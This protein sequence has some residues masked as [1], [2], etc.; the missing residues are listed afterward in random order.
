MLQRLT[1]AQALNLFE[2]AETGNCMSKGF[3]IPSY[4]PEGYLAPPPDYVLFSPEGYINEPPI[5]LLP[6]SHTHRDTTSP[7]RR[8]STTVVLSCQV[9]WSHPVAL[10]LIG[11][12]TW[13]PEFAKLQP[14]CIRVCAKRWTLSIS[15]KLTHEHAIRSVVHTFGGWGSGIG[16]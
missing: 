8:S 3:S 15:H 12:K 6:A 4:P 11:Y 9:P 2:V 16:V 14:R 5:H 7:L 1:A 13:Y 10:S